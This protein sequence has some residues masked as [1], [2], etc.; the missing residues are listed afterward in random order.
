MGQKRKAR[1][2]PDTLEVKPVQGEGPFG[3]YFPSGFDPNSTKC[4]WET[5]QHDERR[6]Q[7]AIVGKT[8]RSGCNSAIYYNRNAYIMHATASSRGSVASAAWRRR[9]PR[10]RSTLLPAVL[11]DHSVDFLATSTNAE[12]SGAIPCR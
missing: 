12:Y 2:V 3:V 5:F 11:Q 10:H 4:T 1:D 6:N 8:V 7:Y 9:P